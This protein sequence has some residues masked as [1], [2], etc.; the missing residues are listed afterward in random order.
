MEN[1]YSR[2]FSP[3]VIKGT[4]FKNRIEVAPTLPFMATPDG[5]V[6]PDFVAYYRSF[7]RSGAAVVT[8]GE[9]TVSDAEFKSFRAQLN[10]GRDE[11]IT[12]LDVAH[13][14]ITRYNTIASIELNH[15][16]HAD[17]P[18][19][20]SEEQIYT[21]IKD[22]AQAAHRCTR[23]GFKMIMVHGGHGHLLAQFL[24]PLTN[25]RSDQ[26]GGKLENRARFPMAVLD[27][28]RQKC[29][30]ELIIEYRVS[31]DEIVTG[32]IRPDEVLEFLTMIEDKIDI[33]HVSAGMMEVIWYVI[34]P[35]YIPHMC[36]VKYAGMVKKKVKLPVTVVG[37]MMNLENSEK[38]LSE[39]NADFI[40]MARPLLADPELIKKTAIGKR[41]EIRPC[42]RCN[43]CSSRGFS[44]QTRCTVNPVAGRGTEFPTEDS[45]PLAGTKKKILV[46]GGG[47]AGMQA[48]LTAARRGHEVVLYELT[49]H[50][51]GMLENATVFPF[52]EDLRNFLSWQIARIKQSPVKVVYNTGVTAAIVQKE[53]PDFLVIAV[54]ATPLLPFAKSGDGPAVC[55]AGDTEIT[56]INAGEKV[57]VVGAGLLGAE[58]ALFFSQRDKKVT[59][60]EMMGAEDVL[61]DSSLIN[62]DYLLDQLSKQNVRIVTG[63]KM[64]TVTNTGVRVVDAGAGHKDYPADTVILAMGMTARKDIVNELRTL[65]PQT[66]VAVIGD[67]YEP[68]NLFAAI[69]DGFNTVVEV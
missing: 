35:Q 64:E 5:V 47:P 14:G 24:S 61:N 10:L 20:I 31:L 63:E 40:A 46:A 32:G 27:A 41:D 6:T 29:G 48:A 30:P 58:T 17:L 15:N 7:A 68:R 16:G 50:L 56:K 12:G 4:E 45:I 13:E 34:Q 11:V 39:G 28:I 55:W 67:C 33:V 3:I 66:E 51:G 23:A 18:G 49:D 57:I 9:S 26:W 42:T 69:H 1:G 22:F 25:K 65:L 36:N 53:K 43:I 44:L 38:V 54:G 52:K 62:R 8:I 60:I 37:S 2:V 59:I 21:D 19:D